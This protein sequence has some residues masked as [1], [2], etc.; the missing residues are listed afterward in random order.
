MSAVHVDAMPHGDAMP[1]GLE[2]HRLRRRL[3]QVG[4]VV[5]LV[6]AVVALVPGLSGVR[7]NLARAQ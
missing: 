2:P 6:G 1:A 4:V 3:V 7:E 5:V